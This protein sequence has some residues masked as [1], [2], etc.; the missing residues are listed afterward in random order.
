MFGFASKG[1]HPVRSLQAA[2]WRALG[3]PARYYN[4]NLHRAAFA[5]P[6]YVEEIVK[7]VE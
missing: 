1:L 5:L 6:T 4:T 2:A 7:H 3:I